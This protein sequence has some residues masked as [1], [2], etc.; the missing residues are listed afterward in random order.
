VISSVRGFLATTIWRVVKSLNRG[1]CITN[2]VTVFIGCGFA[3]KYPEG[4]GNFSV[5]LQWMLGLRRL[6]LDAV[7]LELLPATA[8]A[9]RRCSAHP[10]VP[11]GVS[12]RLDIVGFT[13]TGQQVQQDLTQFAETTGGRYYRAENAQS[14]SRA[15]M[16]AATE[17][18]PYEVYNAAGKQVAAGVAGDDGQELSAGDYRVVVKAGE[19]GLVAEHVAVETGKDAALTVTVKNDQ[20]ELE[21]R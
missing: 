17:K 15:L 2:V 3:A 18:I 4:G 5:P 10:Q 11:A 6:G 12:V 1:Q 21:H 20:F 14:L 8:D 13:L 16:I 9:Q 19:Q 7:W